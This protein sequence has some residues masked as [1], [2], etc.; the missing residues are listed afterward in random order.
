MTR[1]EIEGCHGVVVARGWCRKH[2]N[3][4]HKH[5]DPLRERPTAQERLWSKVEPQSPGCWVWTGTIGTGGYGVFRAGGASA[6]YLKA[7]RAVWVELVGPIPEGLEL[8]HLCKVRHCVNPDHLELVTPA[9]NRA[10]SGNPSAVHARK[11]Y[12]KHGHVLSGDNL[13][14]TPQ[15]WRQCRTCLKVARQRHLNR[16]SST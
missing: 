7:H 15:G 8:D 12:C 6:P 11:A 1:C 9:E 16:R 3:R 10:R 14:V 13:Y 5:G 2:Y 4:W